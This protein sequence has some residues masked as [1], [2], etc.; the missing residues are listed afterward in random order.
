M[1]GW[2]LKPLARLNVAALAIAGASILIMTL[3]G[4]IDVLSTAILG[5]PIPMVYE[6]TE[7]LMV[8]V[9]FLSL[10]HLQLINGNISIDILPNHLGRRGK[11][12]QAAISQAIALAFFSALTWQAWIMAV[13]SWSVREYSL[14]LIA[15]PIYP[16]K[17]AV[18]VGG[19]LTAL[20]CAS[21]L[22]E[23][24]AGKESVSGSPG[25]GSITS[26]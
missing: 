7:T 22:L 23:I 20:C 13:E 4:G 15:F 16:S 11:R 21:R 19:A 10:G 24:L 17:F 25:E 2:A 14:G 1:R 3:I 12:I 5:R 6:L 26:T 18:V 8:M 9:I